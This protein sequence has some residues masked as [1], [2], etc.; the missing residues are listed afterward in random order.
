MFL[1]KKLMIFVLVFSVLVVI[2]EIWNFI[3]AVIEGGKYEPSAKRL[4]WLGLAISY[5]FTI[6]FTG[7][8]VL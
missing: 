6:I 4:L 2:R 7:F 5:I 1:V 3:V 8:S